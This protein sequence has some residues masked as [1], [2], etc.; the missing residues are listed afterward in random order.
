MGARRREA[1]V[2]VAVAV[3]VAGLCV[4]S[5]WCCAVFCCGVLCFAWKGNIS[6]GRMNVVELGP[7]TRGQISYNFTHFRRGRLPF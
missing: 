1:R 2:A 4:C 7:A 6:E 3:A 5:L